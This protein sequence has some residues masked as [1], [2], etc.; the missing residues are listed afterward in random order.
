MFSFE[1][2]SLKYERGSLQVLDQ[3]L[4]P[5]NKAYVTVRDSKEAWA[6]IRSMQVRGAPLIAI[7]AVLGLA[8]EAH[9]A[10]YASAAEAFTSLQSSI[11]H[12]RTSRP[13]AVN[14]FTA[15]DEM[16]SLLES[17]SQVANATAE[18]VMLKND[19]EANRAMGKHGALHILSL[20]PN[21]EKLK[22][23]TICNTGTLATAEYG[24]ALGVVRCLAEMGKLQHVYAC[25]TRP[26][27]QGARLTAFEIVEDKLPGTL[28]CDSMASAL[29]RCHGVDCVIVGADRVAA[30]GDTANKIGTYQLAIAAKYHN[31]PFFSAAP[32]TTLDL[33]IENGSS[34]SLSPEGISVWNPAFDVT[35]SSLLDGIITEI[36]VAVADKSI[37][38]NVDSLIDIPSFLREKGHDTN[39]CHKIVTVRTNAP[40]SFQVMNDK[41]L[42]AYLSSLPHVR[43][44]LGYSKEEN[45][46]L[47]TLEISEVGD[48]NLNF[49]Y[50][51][52]SDQLS[53]EGKR[54]QLVVKQALPYIRVVESWPLTLRRASFEVAALREHHKHCPN[55]VPEVFHFDQNLAI[56]IMQYIA[57]PHLI[58]RKAFIAGMKFPLFAEHLATFLATTLWNTSCLAL[59]GPTFRTR[60]SKWS[61]NVELCGLTERVVFTD[62]YSLNE[63]NRWTSP[64]LDDIAKHIREDSDL[65]TAA[66]IMKGRFLQNCESLI[67][68]DLHSGSVMAS[69]SS[70]YVIDP[71]FAFYGPMG[72]DLGAIF[73]NI[74]LS[75]FSQAAVENRENYAEWLSQQLRSLWDHFESKFL[76]LWNNQAEGTQTR[77]MKQLWYDSLGFAGVKMIR[78]IVGIAHI[79]DLE[80]IENAD[81]R[82]ICER[83]ALKLGMLLVRA[84][85]GA[86][87]GAGASAEADISFAGNVEGVC[88]QALAMYHDTAKTVRA[89]R[90]S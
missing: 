1:S 46:P 57:P 75:I 54:L 12:L 40:A 76:D 18:T 28:I 21:K 6:V 49:V 16:S 36:G 24:T 13:T 52:T 4:L 45:G 79:E 38:D 8:V 80:C 61:K 35:P 81:I 70:T 71:E 87:A 2:M 77:Y 60:V 62:P 39:K 19:A 33:S 3:L 11:E 22:V 20:Y 55:L 59:D 84:G 51:V 7:V 67:H 89:V 47:M 29:M 48:G 50:I 34:I 85:A 74:L 30:N 66:A 56:I 44:L 86:G 32:T 43:E 9:H 23:L 72:F 64:Q 17:T 5:N 10:S 68:G 37:S 15:T 41:L 69:E 78:R 88:T 82:A 90:G 26:Y 65:K 83:A 73:A 63:A 27:N 42:V 31:I 58:L 14:L 53:I 25:E